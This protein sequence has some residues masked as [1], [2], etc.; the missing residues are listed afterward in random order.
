M[1]TLDRKAASSV[2]LSYRKFK[3]SSQMVL[4]PRKSKSGSRFVYVIRC[5]SCVCLHDV[6]SFLNRRSPYHRT[7]WRT[8]L[9]TVWRYRQLLRLSHDDANS[10]NPSR[11]PSHCHNHLRR[12]CW[13]NTRRRHHR[14]DSCVPSPVRYPLPP[15]YPSRCSTYPNALNSLASLH[16]YT[17]TVLNVVVFIALT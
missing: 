8:C 5:C 4:S 17:T 12:E 11:S 9:A 3:L 14:C 13:T 2:Q 15:L 10:T 1:R 6:L 7:Q 16:V